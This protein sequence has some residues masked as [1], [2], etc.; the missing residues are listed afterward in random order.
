LNIIGLQ[1]D[2]ICNVYVWFLNFTMFNVFIKHL[3]PLFERFDIYGVLYVP[4]F[5]FYSVAERRFTAHIYT[6]RCRVD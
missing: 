5:L 6:P 3:K 4:G 2:V 1:T